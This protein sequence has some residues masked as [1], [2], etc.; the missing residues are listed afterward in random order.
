[1]MVTERLWSKI[2]L[3]DGGPGCWEWTGA[4]SDG[5]G[6]LRVSSGGTSAALYAHRLAYEWLRGLI[7]DGLCVLH[8]CDN[9]SCCNP[10]HLFLGTR[11]ENSAD[12][13]RKNRSTFGERNP[14]ARLTEKDI[15]EI[16]RRHSAGESQAGLGREFGVSGSHING[17]VHRRFWKHV[18]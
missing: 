16:L 1:M 14:Q 7:P 15:R 3:G 17:I 5:Y 9:P 13:A 6:S 18:R 4:K 2:C 10:D 11:T 8:H 12:M